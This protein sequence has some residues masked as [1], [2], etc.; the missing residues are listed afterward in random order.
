[1]G[2]R[3][4]I[5]LGFSRPRFHFLGTNLITTSNEIDDKHARCVRSQFHFTLTFNNHVSRT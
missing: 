3:L 5:C 2:E 1:M 4:D